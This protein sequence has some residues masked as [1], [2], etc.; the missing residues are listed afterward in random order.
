MSMLP[1]NEF[2]EIL[3]WVWLCLN[4]SLTRSHLD[5]WNGLVEIVIILESLVIPMFGLTV[6]FLET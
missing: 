2:L 6:L 5:I 3:R 4:V 1:M